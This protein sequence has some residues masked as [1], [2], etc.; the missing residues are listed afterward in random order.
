MWSTPSLPSLSGPLWLGVVAPD[1]IL[2]MD[3]IE[4]NCNYTKLNC[5]KLIVF[6]FNWVETKMC[7][8]L[9]EIELFLIFKLCIYAKLNYLK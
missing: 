7:T 8:E 2:S 9:F 3:Q 5:L 6:P 1:R 4:L